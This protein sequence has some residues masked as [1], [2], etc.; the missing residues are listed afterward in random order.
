VD[1]GFLRRYKDGWI[2][3]LAGGSGGGWW[4]GPAKGA[5]MNHAGIAAIDDEGNLYEVEGL[6]TG[7]RKLRHVGRKP[8]TDRD[9]RKEN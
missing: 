2:E 8:D 5:I 3:T 9:S 6:F 7:V 1:E 4:F